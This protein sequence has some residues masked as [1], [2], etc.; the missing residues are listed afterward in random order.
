MRMPG[1]KQILKHAAIITLIVLMALTMTSCASMLAGMFG[2][3]VDPPAT[4]D[5]SLLFVE[6]IAY[7]R[8]EDGTRS[9]SLMEINFRRG[10]YPIVVDQAGNEVRFE[11]IEALASAGIIYHSANIPSGTYTLKGFRYLWMTHHNFM[12]SP[13]KDLKFDGQRSDEFIEIQELALPEPVQITVKP[14]TVASLGSYK[15]YYELQE[16][17]YIKNDNLQRKDDEYRLNMFRYED[18]N[19][20]DTH[21]LELMQ[22]WTY[23]PWKL[24]NE[25]NPLAK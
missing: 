15:F 17:E 6:M 3:E 7:T 13:I 25:R 22:D 19:P 18:V 2:L 10:F 24:W 5:S 14:G 16:Y 23:K 11:H 8:L 20:N 12:H 9:D 21:L 1:K 4:E